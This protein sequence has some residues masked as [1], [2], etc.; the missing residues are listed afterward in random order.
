MAYKWKRLTLTDAS[1][2]LTTVDLHTLRE[3]ATEI[4][5]SH[6]KSDTVTY[7]VDRNINYTNIC[8]CRC[9]FCAFSRDEDSQDAYVLNKDVLIEKI[10]A[11][12]E[13]GG[14]HVLLQGGLNPK[15]PFS[16]HTE[17]LKLIREFGLH[18]HGY[19]PSEIVFFANIYHM[20]IDEVLAKLK[21]AGLGS[22]PGGGA[23][24]LSDRTRRNLSPKK[25]TTKEYLSVMEKAHK[26]GIKTTATMM[27][28]HVETILQRLVHLK[29]IRDLQDRTNGFTA[30][31]L[32]PYQPWQNELPFKK[33]QPLE[34]LRM[35]AISRIF[36][37]NIPHI[38][39][40][41]VTQGKDVAQ[42]ALYF[43]ADDMGST[44]MEENV[45]SAA[46]TKFMLDEGAIRELISSAGFVP[47]K[48]D[49]L[50]NILE[51]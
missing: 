5:N 37:D 17:M 13:K 14:T 43:G 47:K 36:L 1:R 42:L 24:I 44:M 19:S 10:K 11:T 20:S 21:E 22:I 45:V 41:W 6:N 29:L 8:M 27:F 16:Y 49:V 48:R 18:V 35:L 34:Y 28:G 31:I 15:L 30:F 12:K 32:W 9:K 51:N 3:M 23:E 40:S 38:Q 50:Y 2:L 26:L 39:A 7:A 33:T 25:A 4:R 46:G